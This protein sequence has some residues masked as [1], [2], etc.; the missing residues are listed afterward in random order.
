MEFFLILEYLTN[1]SPRRA[2]EIKNRSNKAIVAIQFFILTL[3]NL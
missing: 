1:K 2:E 3:T